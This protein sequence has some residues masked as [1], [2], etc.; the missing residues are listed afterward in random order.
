MHLV[1]TDPNPNDLP[2]VSAGSTP[3]AQHEDTPDSAADLSERLTKIRER[4]FMLAA[5]Y[6]TTL[7]SD[8]IFEADGYRS[9]FRALSD[10]LRKLDPDAAAKLV[11]GHESL[12]MAEPVPRPTIP[13]ATQELFEL[14]GEVRSHRSYPQPPKPQS[15]ALQNWP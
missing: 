1:S 5:C 11:E 7:S 10:K 3:P 15:C 9:L 4:L 8:I 14:A 6:A 13:L 12:L 2:I